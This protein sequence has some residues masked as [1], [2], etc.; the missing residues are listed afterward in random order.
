MTSLYKIIAIA[1][2]AIGLTQL[3]ACQTLQN[4]GIKPT[5]SVGAGAGV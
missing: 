5:V 4:S 3:S 2:I 1:L